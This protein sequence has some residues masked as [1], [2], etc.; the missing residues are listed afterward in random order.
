MRT[1]WLALTWAPV[2]LVLPGCGR[3][4]APQAR[5]TSSEPRSVHPLSVFPGY[6]VKLMPGD[7]PE[8]SR[9]VAEAR[10]RWAEF[11][12]GWRDH[13][14]EGMF[15][16]KAE[17]LHDAGCEHMWIEVKAMEPEKITGVLANK[18]V[19]S[20]QWREGQV[21]TV[22]PDRIS[23]WAMVWKGA[24]EGYFTDPK[25]RALMKRN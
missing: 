25:L 5:P 2:L 8:I 3:E 19:Y 22:T 7:D 10:V 4:P 13:Q 17:F 20:T 11:L 9:G 18:P 6:G 21:V 15:T 12:A 23:D 1:P 16:V 24:F 14:H